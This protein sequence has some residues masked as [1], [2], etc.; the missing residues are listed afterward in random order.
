M[1]KNSE[2]HS[3]L[4]VFGVDKPT[5]NLFS[6]KFGGTARMLICHCASKVAALGVTTGK[7]TK[8]FRGLPRVCWRNSGLA[9]L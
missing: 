6:L 3:V 9:F 7:K 8:K 4:Q 2:L 5:F 1:L